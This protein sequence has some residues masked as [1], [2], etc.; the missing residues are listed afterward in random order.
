MIAAELCQELD[1]A[2]VVSV[3][4]DA[5]NWKEQGRRRAGNWAPYLS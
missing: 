5:S 1:T 4:I 3:T 2:N